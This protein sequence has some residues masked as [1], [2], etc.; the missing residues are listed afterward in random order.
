MQKEKTKNLKQLMGIT[1]TEDL[2]EKEDY[3][4]IIESFANPNNW[5]RE[6]GLLGELAGILKNNSKDEKGEKI[7]IERNLKDLY[8]FERGQWLA[9]IPDS[10]YSA[11]LVRLRQNLIKE[12]GCNSILE[13][14]LVDIIV[15][16]Y[17]QIMRD[18]RFSNRIIGENIYLP[19]INKKEVNIIKALNKGAD[20]ANRRLSMATMVLKELKQPPL[21]FKIKTG[22]AFIARNQQVNIKKEEKEKD[23]LSPNNLGK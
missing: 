12:L 13:T 21:T 11:T 23:L 4:Q 15:G 1:E 10:R 14:M 19:E 7:K 22:T 17:W 5:I 2:Q 9:D 20:L 6:E 18:E 8:A 16:A 3:K